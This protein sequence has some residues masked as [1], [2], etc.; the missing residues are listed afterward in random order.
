MPDVA[1]SRRIRKS[2][3]IATTL[4]A[5]ARNDVEFSERGN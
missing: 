1:I 4:C 2:K 3:G 5:L